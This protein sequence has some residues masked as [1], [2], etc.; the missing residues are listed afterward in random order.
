MRA[1]YICV[2]SFLLGALS[3]LDGA[4]KPASAA[5]YRV[6]DL[7]I[8]EQALGGIV[9]GPNILSEV[10]GGSVGLGSHPRSF[11][12]TTTTLESL[13]ALPGGDWSAS[14][15]INEQSTVVGSSNAAT[16]VRAYRWKRN[17][18]LVDLG[19]VPSDTGSEAFGIN[20]HDEA[21]GY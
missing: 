7:G 9:R 17:R 18:G 11:L 13:G 3:T 6:L 16:S 8:L 5:S 2:I 19:T 10:V 4:L 20:K 1:S 15:A 14:H 12:L 21:V